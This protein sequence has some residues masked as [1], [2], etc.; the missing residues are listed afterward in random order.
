MRIS[1]QRLLFSLALAVALTGTGAVF[2]AQAEVN[3]FDARG[4]DQPVHLVLGLTPG[5]DEARA[6]AL[7]AERGAEL[8]RWLPELGLARMAVAA[9]S[10]EATTQGLAAEPGVNFVAEDRRSAE[11]AETPLDEH[12][13]QQWGPAIVGLPAARDIAWGDPTVIIAVVD[14]GVSYWHLD[15]RDQIWIN[16]G[17]S[18]VDP[19]TGKRTCNFG[20]AINGADDDGNG[21]DD[22]CRGYNFDSGTSDPQDVFG[23]GTA[24]AGIASAATNNPDPYIAGGY[25]GIAGMGGA[26]Q[27]M[28]L[29]AM[30]SSGRGTPFSIAEAITYAADKGAQVVNLSVTLGVN[31]VPSD[32]EILCRATSYAQARGA[33][34]VGASGNHSNAETVSAVSYPAACPGVLAVGASTLADVRASFSNGGE[35]LDLVAPGQSI[36][37]TLRTGTQSYGPWN[38]SGL[39]TSFA[40]P[41]AAGA[42]A[43]IRGLRPDLDQA[44]VVELLRSSADDLQPAGF[45]PA[46]GWGRLNAGRAVA[47][48]LEGATLAIA[49]EP[50]GVGANG[51]TAVTLQM[52]GAD[53]QPAGF[54]ARVG[55]AAAMGVV[56]PTIAT[57]DETGTAVATFAAGA[58]IG[59]GQVTATIGSLQASVP[60]TI[61]SGIPHS[62]ILASQPA[63]LPAGG[64]ATV[65]ASVYDDGGNLVGSGFEV[66]FTATLGAVDPPAAETTRGH[67][68]TRFTAGDAEGDGFV[69]ATADGISAGLV[70][71]VLGAGQPFTV[72]V[73]AAPLVAQAGGADVT[74]MAD[75]VDAA[76]I[77]VPDGT[78]VDFSTTLGSLA[79]ASAETTGGKASVKLSPGTAAGSATVI[80]QSGLA[81]GARDIPILA[82]PAA[83]V[84]VTAT[85]AEVIA[86]YNQTVSIRASA[87][88]LYGNAIL[89]GVTIQFVTT[90]GELVTQSAAIVNG[91]AEVQLLGGLVAGIAKV[92]AT[93]PGGAKGTVSVTV[94]PNS[95]AA[96]TLSATPAELT[97]GGGASRLRSVV[98]DVH[99]N[100][101]ADGTPVTFSTDLGLIRPLGGQGGQQSLPVSTVSGVAEAE[102]S[103]GTITGVAQVLA[104]IAPDIQATA[105]VVIKPAAAAS[106]VLDA[107][108]RFVSAGG[109]VD[110]AA[111]VFD[112]FGNPAPDGIDVTFGV[113]AG[114]LYQSVVTT[115]GGAATTW[116][117]A[118]QAPGPVQAVA[119]AGGLSDSTTIQVGRP[120]YLPLITRQ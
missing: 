43:L 87:E 82:G 84:T 111:I 119:V 5:L 55:L 70:I 65:T 112:Q 109:R 25:E 44:A 54:G 61:T 77:P 73:T 10:Q 56:T 47:G 78:T 79:P 113:S 96:A 118:P 6:R 42:A 31:P 101:V 32:A 120:F 102:L 91:Y 63:Y 12:W 37:S 40:A 8:E 2:P 4:V 85:P 26:T 57:L 46:T 105:E 34:V 50:P 89:G 80:A 69:Q 17:E 110:L 48:S 59:Q 93:A 66:A 86:D 68:E 104:A 97:A 99:G 13:S 108:P 51:Q 33:L 20:I 115:S 98:T 36:F 90:L 64:R 41:H 1:P 106:I 52:L 18:E 74:I 60:I 38:G 75:V 107:E 19:A 71:P 72:T 15:L 11:V 67:A 92:T 62:M 29:R 3:S 76:G 114:S 95:P 21:Y 9:G 58:S 116:F 117:T 28:A 100:P 35:R 45:D 81:Q 94:R 23:H 27:L 103:P 49:A 53:G 7:A 30:D 22:D 83:S 14:T 39:G 88:D 24:V 16:P